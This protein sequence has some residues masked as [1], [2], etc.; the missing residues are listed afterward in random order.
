MERLRIETLCAICREENLLFSS[1]YFA[2]LTGD[3]QNF[4]AEVHKLDEETQ[5]RIAAQ[6]DKHAAYLEDLAKNG[7]RYVQ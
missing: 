3:V 2:A 1:L 7:S 6:M 5:L 4:K